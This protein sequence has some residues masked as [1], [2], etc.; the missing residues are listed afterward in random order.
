MA[1]SGIIGCGANCDC[2]A[3]LLAERKYVATRALRIYFVLVLFTADAD[4]QAMGTHLDLVSIP[5]SKVKK[6]QNI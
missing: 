4:F 3:S 5:L 1:I 2:C 6:C